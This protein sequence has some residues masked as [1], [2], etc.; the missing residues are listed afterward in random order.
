MYISLS[1]SKAGNACAVKQSIKN[2]T[3]GNNKTQFFDW[4]VVSMKSVNQLLENTPILFETNYFHNASNKIS[5]NFKNFDLLTSHH[6]IHEFNDNSIHELTE[7]YTRRYN[8]LIDTIKEQQHIHFIRYCNSN[9]F[10]E[11][12]NFYTN[13]FKI[14]PNLMFTFILISDCD[15]PIEMKPNLIFI[16][17]SNYI[18]DLN[19]KD[20]YFEIIKRYKCVFNNSDV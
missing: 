6:D 12:N 3:T 10:D 15:I 1:G 8:R 17:L 19:K 18:V 14:N 9:E 5:I 2:Y 16:N 20:D 4:L 11:I 7:K 13:I